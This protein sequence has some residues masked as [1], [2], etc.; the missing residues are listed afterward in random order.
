MVGIAL[1]LGVNAS[2]VRAVVQKDGTAMRM[3][4]ARFR[5]AFRIAWRCNERFTA[6]SMH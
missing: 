1:A 2:Q 4:S 5:K 6:I 3:T